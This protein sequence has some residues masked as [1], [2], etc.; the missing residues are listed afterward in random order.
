MARLLT[1]VIFPL[2]HKGTALWHGKIT[3]I[4]PT[5]C[6]RQMPDKPCFSAQDRKQRNA[7]YNQDSLHQVDLEVDDAGVDLPGQIVDTG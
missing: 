7:Q 3:R 5:T 1:L 6:Q 2:A 4:R